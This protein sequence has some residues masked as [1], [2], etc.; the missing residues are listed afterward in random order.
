LI[1]TPW[2][3]VV[4]MALLG[5]ARD[6]G[7]VLSVSR[8]DYVLRVR[9]LAAPDGIAAPSFPV[10]LGSPRHPTPAGV[11][12][13]RRVIWSPRYTPGPFARA[14]GA[15]PS[16][17]SIDGPLGI[18]KIHFAPG[19]V[20]LHGGAHPLALGKPL[21]LGCIETTDSDLVALLAWLGSQQ[22]LARPVPLG[23]GELHQGLRRPVRVEVR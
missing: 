7:L 14:I 21:S 11:F 5:S 10:V 1:F 20:A 8:S 18:A 13:L 2:I 15:L 16:P 6:P 22:A 19:G 23:D 9:D 17:P 12:P 4:A 3:A